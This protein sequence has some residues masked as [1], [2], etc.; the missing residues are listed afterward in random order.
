MK[1]RV[2]EIRRSKGLSQS[3]LAQRVGAT[4]SMIGKLERGEREM[5]FYWLDRI[6][7][8]LEVSVSELFD[9]NN[10]VVHVGKVMPLTGIVS[11]DASDIVPRVDGVPVLE[12]RNANRSWRHSV[13]LDADTSMRLPAGAEFVF[14][15]PGRRPS[16][17]N[18]GRLSMVWTVD[19]PHDNPR[20]FTPYLG[21][22]MLGSRPGRY[23][24][25]P[26]SGEPIEDVHVEWVSPI[27]SIEFP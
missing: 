2:A 18:V 17:A 15:V 1:F 23:H 21:F 16:R 13:S 12:L 24:L 14:S 10:S 4:L 25:V 27:I 19:E 5:T 6:A 26:I 20:P 22:I 3:Q 9:E 7:E 8:V 11:E